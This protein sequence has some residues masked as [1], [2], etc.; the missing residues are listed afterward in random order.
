MILNHRTFSHIEKWQKT[1]FQNPFYDFVPWSSGNK[2]G[3]ETKNSLKGALASRGFVGERKVYIEWQQWCEAENLSV[4]DFKKQERQKELM[5][6][7][8]QYIDTQREAEVELHKVQLGR[9]Y[10]FMKQ[11]V[12]A[13]V[14]MFEKFQEWIGENDKNFMEYV[15]QI[16][17]NTFGMYV[18]KYI[19]C[20]VK[21]C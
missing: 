12:N 20:V 11:V 16:C 21:K 6:L 1:E 5:A 15:L 19:G 3:L 10:D 8:Q 13:G 4:L 17:Y 18:C 9:A 14:S 2:R 7:N